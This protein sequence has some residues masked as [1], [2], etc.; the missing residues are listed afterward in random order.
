MRH[1]DPKLTANVYTGP[2]LLDI[3][4]AL[5]ALPMLPDDFPSPNVVFPGTTVIQ[6]AEFNDRCSTAKCRCWQQKTLGH[7]MTA[8]VFKLP[9][10][11]LNLD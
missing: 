9:G 3:H 4:S 8:S 11:D 1:S 10:E 7:R 2:R 5:D 6:R